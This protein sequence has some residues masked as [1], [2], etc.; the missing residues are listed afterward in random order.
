MIKFVVQV[1]LGT[2]PLLIKKNQ[3]TIKILLLIN[4]YRIVEISKIIVLMVKVPYFYKEDKSFLAISL[5]VWLVEKETYFEKMDKLHQENG[6]I[7]CK[8]NNFDNLTIFLIK[9]NKK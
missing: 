9:V 2:V 7:I 4:G 1:K 5:K 6:K 8:L 3:L